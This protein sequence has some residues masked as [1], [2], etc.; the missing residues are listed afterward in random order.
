MQTAFR[1]EERYSMSAFVHWL[2]ARPPGDIHRYE[3]LAGHIVMTPPASGL[4]G[5]I[6]AQL[7]AALFNHVEAHRL[8]RIFSSSTGYELPSG[9]IVEPDLSFVCSAKLAA[10]PPLAAGKFARFVPDLVVEILS[11]TTARRDRTE[12]QRIYEKNGV[13]EYWIVSPGSRSVSMS[14][15]VDGAFTKPVHL[16]SEEIVS[17]AVPGLRLPVS[18][19]FAG[20]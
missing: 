8:G 2:R 12:K 5:A 11:P 6:E 20:L 18:K 16:V 10:G 4:H 3:L 17:R 19:V 15:L 9:D 7:G 1:S 14:H 13:A